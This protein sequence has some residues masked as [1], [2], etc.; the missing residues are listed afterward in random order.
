MEETANTLSYFTAGYAVILGI[1][2]AYLVSLIVRW[3]N[4]REEEKILSTLEQ[5]EDR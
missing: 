5:P 3:R 1:M 2:L 4:L